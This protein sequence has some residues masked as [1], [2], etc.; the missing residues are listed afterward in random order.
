MWKRQLI[1]VPEPEGRWDFLSSRIEWR[2]DGL[3]RAW[4]HL[5]ANSQSVTSI[6]QTPGWFDHVTS[7]ESDRIKLAVTHDASGRVVG[8]APIR[9]MQATLDLHAKGRVLG[10][11]PMRKAVLVGGRPVAPESTGVL[12]RLFES[13]SAAIPDVDAIAMSGIETDSFLWHYLHS[14]DF[15]HNR[16]L[17]FVPEGVRP[18]HILKL[19]HTFSEYLA[20][21]N[22]KKRYNLK[23]QLRILRERGGG[24]LDLRRIDSPEGAACF[25][26]AQS[27]MEI[28]GAGT[29]GI[30]ARRDDVSHWSRYQVVDLGRRGFLRSYVLT[31]GDDPVSMIKGVQHRSTYFALQTLFRTEYA[32]LSPGA[33]MFPLVVEDLLSERPATSIEFGFGEPNQKHH[34]AN[35][36]VSVARVLLMRK[37]IAN[38]ILC[39]THAAFFSGIRAA[40]R[41][42]DRCLGT[43]PSRAAM[44]L[45]LLVNLTPDYGSGWL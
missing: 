5:L 14:S 31:C 23:R 43:I 26:D 8:I 7:V 36:T 9:L 15:I 20:R 22:A 33:T 10:R 13:I 4:R 21:F 11:L 32:S 42:R 17:V 34:A 25:L 3:R 44:A 27:R 45:W 2:S 19:P 38:R 41:I 35:T 1:E 39:G 37:T 6:Y 24:R 16:F 12:D 28:E 18:Y 29:A 30:A 40:K